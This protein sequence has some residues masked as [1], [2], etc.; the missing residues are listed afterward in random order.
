[1][2]S[3]VAL[4]KI[5]DR[6]LPGPS[7][8]FE[9][10]HVLLTFL[11]IGESDGIGR[12]ALAAHSGLGDGSVRTVLKKLRDEGY[13]QVDT[14]GCHLTDEGRRV[15]H[16]T[17]R[18]LSTSVSLKGSSLTVG[19]FQTALAIRGEAL[20]VGSGIEQRDSAVRL[21]AAGATTYFIKGDKFTVPGGSA[22]CEREYPSPAW[23]ALRRDLNPEN[24]D[25]VVLC[26]ASKE[27][28]ATLGALAAALTLL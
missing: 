28:A 3:L 26:G 24:G 22:D 17:R 25:A 6:R 5:A 27:I 7:P 16:S 18:K 1:M 21:G 23:Q 2:Q 20:S 12:H 4:L 19:T 8:G 13:V 11:T 9:R 15:F 14:A 10:A